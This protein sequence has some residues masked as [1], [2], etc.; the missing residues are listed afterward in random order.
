MT[1]ITRTARSV[2]P[3][4]TTTTTPTERISL[5]PNPA[6]KSGKEL[7]LVIHAYG[8]I[9]NRIGLAAAPTLPEQ[10]QEQAEEVLGFNVAW[11]SRAPGSADFIG[12][13]S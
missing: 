6:P 13:R 5:F 12:T 9:S 8:D 3:S 2:A 1:G 11:E 7:W 10:A 4:M